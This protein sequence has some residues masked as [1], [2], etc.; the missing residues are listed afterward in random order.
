M[1]YTICYWDEQDQQ[2]KEREA[3]EDEVA[4]ILRRQSAPPEVPKQISR[5]Q[6]RLALHQTGHFQTVVDLISSMPEPDKTIN[7]I[8]WDDSPSYERTNP[9][10]IAL[11]SAIGLTSI[12][13]DN[14]F[15]LA[16]AL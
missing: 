9:Y 15:I 3:G 5:K 4:D 14:L 7:T 12:D 16:E 6:A 8:Q 2:Q 13:I 11:G 10:L 1:S